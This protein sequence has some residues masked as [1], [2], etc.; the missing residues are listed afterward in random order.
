MRGYRF[1]SLGLLAILGLG[2]TSAQASGEMLRLWLNSDIR[3]TDP[4]VNRDANTDAVELHMVEGLVAYREDASVGPMLAKSI[5]VA[6][7]G[8]THTFRLRDGVTFHNGAPLTADDVLFAWKRYLD[9]Q[10]NWRC[11]SEFD[12]RGLTKITGITAPDPMSV[13]FTL[14]KPSALFLAT[15]ARVDCGEAGIYHRSSLDADGKWREPVGTGPFKFGEW[16]HGE[17]ID[18]VRFDQYAAL[19]GK[20]DGLTG[21]K[22][23]LVPKLR[24][25]IIPDPSAAKAALMA[26]GVDVISRVVNSDLPE[27]KARKDVVTESAP[28]MEVNGFLFQTRDPLLRD[29]RIRQAFALA[30]DVPQ[31]VEA[32]TEGESK[33]SLSIIPL[34]SPYYGKPQADMPRR[35][36]AAAKKLLAEAGYKGQP[37]KMIT[38]K[39]YEP[40]FNAAVLAQAMVAEAGIKLD[41]EVLDWATELDRYT[42][43]DYQAMSFGYSARLD[44]SLSFEMVGGDKDKQPRKVWDNPE[45]LALLAKSMQV[46]AQPDRQAIFDRMEALFRA[47]MP[48][49]PL[50]AVFQTSGVRAD[51]VGYH[52]WALGQPRGWGVSLK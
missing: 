45:G 5:E 14:D 19:P 40:M 15:M 28:T 41:L 7:D 49:I 16:K 20:P 42:K 12:G 3:S 13:A 32:T 50:Y 33:P 48:M 39:R 51:V 38:N 4:G 25:V 29:V 10:N 36:V 9:P 30:L 26:D 1:L 11:L 18:L 2:A 52:N 35:D 6:P 44:P 31:L 47:D 21:N 17:Y 27:L 34:P 46:S 22:S 24:F 37:I 43:G 23:P 8:L